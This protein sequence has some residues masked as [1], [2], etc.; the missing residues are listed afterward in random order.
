[1]LINDDFGQQF[2][3]VEGKITVYKLKKNKIEEIIFLSPEAF[4]KFFTE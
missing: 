4:P 3:S 2:N 1:M